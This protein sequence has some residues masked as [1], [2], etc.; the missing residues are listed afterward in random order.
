MKSYKKKEKKKRMTV[1]WELKIK[2]NAE[3]T[4]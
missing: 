4:F 1:P 3:A 2:D